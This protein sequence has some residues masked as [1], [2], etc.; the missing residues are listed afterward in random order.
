MEA[1]NGP[2]GRGINRGH[3]GVRAARNTAAKPALRSYVELTCGGMP[4]FSRADSIVDHGRTLD[5]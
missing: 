4:R 2:G 5:A 1:P 3:H